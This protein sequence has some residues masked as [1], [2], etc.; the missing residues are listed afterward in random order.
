MPQLVPPHPLPENA[1]TAIRRAAAPQKPDAFAWGPVDSALVGIGGD[2]RAEVV[3]RF[4]ALGGSF[5]RGS[6]RDAEL[7]C[8]AMTATEDALELAARGRMTAARLALRGIRRE[9]GCGVW[10]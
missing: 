2:V 9:L 4:R 7:A 6:S 1:P 5:A 3:R 10:P 8:D